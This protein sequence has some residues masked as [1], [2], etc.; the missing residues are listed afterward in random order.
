MVK[1]SVIVVNQKQDKTVLRCL[2]SVLE[3]SLQPKEII[4]VNNGAMDRSLQ[5]IND[6]A[7]E[8]KIPFQVL[9]SPFECLSVARNRGVA[10]ATGNYVAFLDAAYSWDGH[11]LEKMRKHLKQH[12]N[13]GLIGVANQ[14]PKLQ[15]DSE[16]LEHIPLRKLLYWDLFHPSGTIIKKDILSR[17]GGFDESL[18]F[19]ESYE[20][21]TRIA[22]DY[23]SV[24]LRAPLVMEA[25]DQNSW[26]Q[27]PVRVQAEKR[28]VYRTLLKEKKITVWD[29]T[30]ALAFSELKRLRSFAYQREEQQAQLNEERIAYEQS[31]IQH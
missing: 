15:Q 24:I 29:Y 28:S 23:Y 26:Q 30:T 8:K 13:I 1:I 10:I 16:A 2:L 12:R 17:A 20:Y 21:S 22:G 19:A 5:K 4:L 11:F 31:R 7:Q 3:Q 27:P 25:A 9:E 18:L 14:P 6:L